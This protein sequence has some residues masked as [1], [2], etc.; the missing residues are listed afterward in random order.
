MT[1]AGF[2]V[3][4]SFTDQARRKHGMNI[5]PA[6]F[7]CV[8]PTWTWCFSCGLC[9]Y[10]DEVAF[11][12]ISF[13]E[14][15]EG[16]PRHDSTRHAFGYCPLISSSATQ[17]SCSSPRG[18]AALLCDDSR[19]V[20]KDVLTPDLCGRPGGNSDCIS[21]IARQ[22]SATLDALLCRG[23]LHHQR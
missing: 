16:P 14:I 4:R 6:V 23:Q 22:R 11:G 3:H 1:E 15:R 21:P 5:L 20:A 13:F 8:F 18:P 19:G 2:V 10:P 7:V 9:L 17:N 12:P